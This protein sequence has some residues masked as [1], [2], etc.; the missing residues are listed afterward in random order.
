MRMRQLGNGQSVV[1]CVNDEVEG[2]IRGLLGKP[3]PDTVSVKDVLL[4]SIHETFAFIRHMMPLWAMQGKRFVNHEEC[5]ANARS[6]GVTTMTQTHSEKFLEDEAQSIEDRYRPRN[7]TNDISYI[8]PSITG[9][10]ND[11]AKRCN[12]FEKLQFNSSALQEEQERELSPEIEQERQVQRPPAAYPA[13]PML[14]RHVTEFFT[15]AKI[16]A[17]TQAYMPAF[18]GL[19]DTS[20]F[21]DFKA[22]ALRCDGKLLATADFVNTVKKSGGKARRLDSYQRPVQ[23]VLVRKGEKGV[24]ADQLMIISPHEAQAL[25]QNSKA[26]NRVT[27]HVYKACTNEAHTILDRLD[28]LELPRQESLPPTIPKDIVVQLNLFAGQL[29]LKSYSDYQAVC[30]FLGL[31]TGLPKPGEK[32][33]PDGFIR[34]EANGKV[35][36]RQSP[37]KFLQTLMSIRKNGGSI[38]KT[39]MGNILEGKLLKASE[40]DK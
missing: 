2:K 11:I 7:D 1:F 23:W 5:W 34:Q 27:M 32:H 16:S 30:D 19:R 29:Y 28:F 10:L 3:K 22:C 6:K 20:T 13:D 14:H 12:E 38:G 36:I 25:L 24:V 33:D 4:W 17:K 15:S 26:H 39:H 31:A 9:R 40:F 21:E 18:D 8:I 35:K 37:V